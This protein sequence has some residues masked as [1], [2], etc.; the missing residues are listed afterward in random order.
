MSNTLAHDIRVA[1]AGVKPSSTS[2]TKWN[3]VQAVLAE[4]LSV[5]RED[6]YPATVS[7]KRNLKVRG[8]QSDPAQG[9]SVYAAMYTGSNAEL[10][11][12]LD[13]AERRCQRDQALYLIFRDHGHGFDLE[14][15]IHPASASVPAVLSSAYPKA[16][17]ISC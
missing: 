15:I 17:V 14:A 10:P 2:N 1:A 8:D 4:A 13:S 11:G 3:R 16:L 6:V 5:N 9:K 7:Y 12:T